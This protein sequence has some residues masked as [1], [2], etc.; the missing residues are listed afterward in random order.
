MYYTG[1]FIKY[2]PWKPPALIA[3]ASVVAGLALMGMVLGLGLGI[4]LNN[5]DQNLTSITTTTGYYKSTSN[6]RFSKHFLFFFYLIV[7]NS[8]IT[9][10][11]S[12]TLTNS[13]STYSP[14]HQPIPGHYYN[15]IRLTVATF[16]NYTI[17]SSSGIN[18]YGYLYSSNFDPLNS[19]LNLI[20]FDDNSGGNQQFQ[21]TVLLQ[22]TS[23]TSKT[24]KCDKKQFVRTIF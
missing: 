16:G 21:M 22:S 6:G 7:N 5:G 18:L 14:P 11:F 1:N 15:A 4:G 9:S 10:T 12:G 8:L 20:A 17:R 2:N 24:N 13:S 23:T 19:S 3:T